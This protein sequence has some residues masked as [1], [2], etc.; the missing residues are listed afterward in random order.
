MVEALDGVDIE[1]D[2]LVEELEGEIFGVVELLETEDLA[3][4][5]LADGGALFIFVGE[6]GFVHHFCIFVGLIAC[7]ID[8][9]VYLLV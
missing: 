7:L 4:E 3:D 8:R 6:D 1:G 5:A 2:H 9:F